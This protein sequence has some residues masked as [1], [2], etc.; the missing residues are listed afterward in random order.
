MNLRK[1]LFKT[2]ETITTTLDTR[3]VFTANSNGNNNKLSE[4]QQEEKDLLF[5]DISGYDDIKKLFRM[6]INA[7]DAVHVLLIGAPA[8]AK[9][10]FMRTWT[11]LQNSYFTDGGNGTKAGM[12]GHIINNEPKYLLIDEIDKMST[13]DQ[14]FLLNLMETG[15]VSETKHGKTRTIQ[16][17]K[18][19]LQVVII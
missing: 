18:W 3:V 19:C 2:K 10:L 15:I 12:I 13:Q 16:M 8:S 11:Q 7:N 1:W 14:T 17:K 4:K 5:E 9:T 6:A